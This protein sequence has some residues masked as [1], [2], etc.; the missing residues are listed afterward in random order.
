MRSKII[1]HIKN[2]LDKM[3][4]L[5]CNCTTPPFTDPNHGHIVT[6]D[7]HIVQNNELR[8]LLCKSPK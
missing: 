6:G 5:P 2:I 8:K 4:D 1:N 3:N 7:M